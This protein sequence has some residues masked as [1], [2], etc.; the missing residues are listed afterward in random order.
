MAATKAVVGSG[1]MNTLIKRIEATLDS[2]A[3]WVSVYFGIAAIFFIAL[4]AA[5]PKQV[6]KLPVADQKAIAKSYRVP[7]LDC[8]ATGALKYR[9]KPVKVTQGVGNRAVTNGF[10]QEIILHFR[11]P[12]RH[13]FSAPGPDRFIPAIRAE[14][15]K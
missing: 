5:T 1:A 7:C 2:T 12:V 10:M 15:E 14:E 8:N 4:V 9:L 6:A 3:F 13:E 11:C